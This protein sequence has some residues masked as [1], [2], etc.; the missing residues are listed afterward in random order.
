[1]A[2]G[3]IAVLTAASH[4]AKAD[5]YP[6]MALKLAPQFYYL[7]TDEECLTAERAVT[8]PHALPW[9]GLLS[10]DKL[11]QQTQQAIIDKCHATGFVW[12]TEHGPDLRH[13]VH[14]YMNEQVLVG[15]ALSRYICRQTHGLHGDTADYWGEDYSLD[16][17][18]DVN[19]FSPEMCDY[20]NATKQDL[21]EQVSHPAMR[22]DGGVTWPHVW[23]SLEWARIAVQNWR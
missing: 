8:N 15:L 19:K 16:E 18:E 12:D 4:S 17:N 14:L 23:Q 22:S 10:G 13:H 7:W 6:S 20:Y 3:I 11:K 9:T 21:F 1:M 5:E 2:L